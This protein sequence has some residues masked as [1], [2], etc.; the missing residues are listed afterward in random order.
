MKTFK[1]ITALLLAATLTLSLCTV[2]VPVE[3][4]DGYGET[5]IAPCTDDSDFGEIDYI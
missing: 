4:T 5:G 1:R 2:I 3:P